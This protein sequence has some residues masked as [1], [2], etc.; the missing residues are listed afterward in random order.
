[1]T[2]N[3]VSVRDICVVGAASAVISVLSLLHIP[4]PFGIPVTLQTFVIPFA[5][6]I[7][8]PRKG[9]LSAV[10]YILIGAIG[11]PVFT[12]FSS[13]IGELLGIRGGFL[14]GFPFMALFAGL[15]AKKSSV[16]SI[17]LGL[18]LGIIID[19]TAGVLQFMLVSG[20]SLQTAFFACVAPFLPI[21]VIKAGI[22]GTVGVKCRQ[23]L[24]KSGLITA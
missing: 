13:G 18:A 10:I 22:V 14:W 11:I 23:A 8:G 4:L 16:P 5:G 2:K 1:M 24:L 3:K 19:Y 7:L 6:V 17:V 9:M 20:N 21:E 12:G 15:G